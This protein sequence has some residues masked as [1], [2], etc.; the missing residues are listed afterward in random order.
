MK[1]LLF[2]LSGICVAAGL[3]CFVLQQRQPPRPV[4]GPAE[5]SA[6]TSSS[7][8]SPA[9]PAVESRPQAKPR[10][11]LAS[12]PA[13][14]PEPAAAAAAAPSPAAAASVAA[15]QAIQTLASPQASYREKQVAWGLLRNSGKLDM[16]ITE[17]EQRAAANPTVAEYPATLGQAYLQKAGTLSDLREQGILGLKADQSFDAA[18]NADPSNWEA[19]FWKA[20][21]MSY[22]PAQ[23]GKS[24]EVV[25]RFVELIKMQETQTPQPEFAQSYVILGEQ[26]Q[27]QGYAD[28]ANQVW[29]RGASL[30]PD[31]ARLKNKLENPSSNQAAAR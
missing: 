19:G 16:A 14:V 7:P 24:Q 5:V 28:Y 27:K 20:S 1:T 29:Q 31:D 8:A 3:A 6:P 15:Q 9:G 22:W 23:L 10:L 26:Y 12:T 18:L 11:A 25:D 21:A 30:F 17:F 13:P 2:V 4:A